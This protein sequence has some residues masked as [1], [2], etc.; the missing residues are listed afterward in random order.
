MKKGICYGSLPGDWSDEEKLRLAKRAGYDGVEVH[1]LPDSASRS[2]MREL[3][4]RIGI[5]L[6][7]IM[8]SGAWEYPLSSPEESVR[9]QGIRCI[10]D[11]VDT[12][13]AVGATT[14]LLVPG[15]LKESQSYQQA[16]NAALESTRTLAK[17]AEHN[18]IQL[19]VENV[20]NRLLL[21]P[22]EMMQFVEAVGSPNVGVYF[23]C[24]NIL[25]YGYPQ[26]WIRELGSLIRKVHVKDFESS[27]RQWR[28]LLQGSVNWQEVRAAL[29]EIGYNDYLTAELPLYPTYPDQMVLDTA[30]HIDRIIAGK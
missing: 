3:A 13:K 10:Q 2:A 9:S 29:L 16:Y 12:A 23:D 8:P 15:S 22:R 17:Y 11:A 30:Q 6:P 26:V 28:H 27:T 24:G 5:E 18:G 4:G 7:S 14:V 1:T 25:A 20:W 19:A 21:T